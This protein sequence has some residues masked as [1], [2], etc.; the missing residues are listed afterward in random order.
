MKMLACSRPVQRLALLGLVGTVLF[1]STAA[2]VPAQEKAPAP[3]QADK[4]KPAVEDG[5]K[6]AKVVEADRARLAPVRVGYTRPGYPN[7]KVN[8]DGSIRPLA[9]D[10]EYRDKRLIGGSVYFLVLERTGD[11]GD[12]WGTGIADFDRRFVEGKNFKG[13][14]STTLSTQSRYLYLY[15]VVNDRGLDPAPIRPAA[16]IEFPTVP[17]AASALKLLVDPRHITSWGHFRGLGLT[18][19][20]EDRNAK[21]EVRG[22]AE[23]KPA[24]PIRLAVSSNPSVLSK[25]PEKRY[26][27][28]APAN[29]LHELRDSL[30]LGS[31]TLNLKNSLA[32]EELAKQKAKLAS[33][34]MN[35][36][37]AA[38]AAKEPTYVQI[39]YSGYE[40]RVVP[41]VGE[42]QRPVDGEDAD[43]LEANV[44]FRADWRGNNIMKLGHHSVIFGF[45]TDLPPIDET[46][47][48][49]DDRAA[50]RGDGIVAAVSTGVAPGTAPTPTPPAPAATRTRPPPSRTSSTSTP[51]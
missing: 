11:E 2:L 46:I 43:L 51:R 47:R 19:K 8:D 35:I 15:M 28:K 48:I 7:D 4:A 37:Q 49:E 30:T 13:S 17:V 21:D 32:Y 18:V 6:D 33:W 9:W 39:L 36:I 41:V 16:D 23:G 14:F 20:V 27:S 24:E 5:K 10:P 3:R 26:M 29:P 44:V 12:T 45:T 22:A 38:D 34:G 40:D 50:L 31:A 42:G 1:W 25:L